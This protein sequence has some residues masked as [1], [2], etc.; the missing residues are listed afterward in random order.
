MNGFSSGFTIFLLR[1]FH[2]FF[3]LFHGISGP[4]IEVWGRAHV[5]F[6][7]CSRMFSSCSDMSFGHTIQPLL[8]GSS[9]AEPKPK[10]KPWLG[11]ERV[12]LSP[13]VSRSLKINPAYFEHAHLRVVSAYLRV[14]Q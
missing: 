11:P 6:T 12:I 5:F 2:D 8:Q 9:T 14:F 1:F 4:L 13:H 3:T 10:T 7:L